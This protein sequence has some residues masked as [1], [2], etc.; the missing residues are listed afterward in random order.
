MN[1]YKNHSLEDELSKTKEELMTAQNE[2][3]TQSDL[4]INMKDNYR[5]TE[6][7]YQSL[8]KTTE[9]SQELIKTLEGEKMRLEHEMK[10]YNKKPQPLA[11]TQQAL[12]SKDK[13]MNELSLFE[14]KAI[15]KINRIDKKSAFIQTT[16]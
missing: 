13:A 1:R 11:F 4:I 8:L 15:S 12:I 10:K 9:F 16:L 3:S 2:L 6:H 5:K 14:N 7:E